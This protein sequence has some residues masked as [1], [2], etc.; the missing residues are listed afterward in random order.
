MKPILNASVMDLFARELDLRA[1]Q[2]LAATTATYTTSSELPPV[3]AAS[4]GLVPAWEAWTKALER[5]D[6][7]RIENRYLRADASY[8]PPATGQAA[9]D[10]FVEAV[11]IHNPSFYTTMTP[12]EVHR[13]AALAAAAALYYAR[14]HAVIEPTVAL[15]TWLAQ[16]DIGKDVPASLFRM[17]MPALFLRFGPE[18]AKAVDPSLWEHTGHAHTTTGVYLFETRVG[19]RR[20]IVFIAVGASPGRPADLP[21]LLQLCLTDES[22]S[23]IE[24]TLNV[25]RIGDIRMGRSVAM[26]QMCAKVLLYLQTPGVIRADELR[27]NETAA[28]LSRVGGK[29]ASKLERRLTSRYNR[30]IVGPSQ[31]IHYGPGE[32]ASHWRR[33]HLRMQAHGPHFSLRKL[34]F[35]APT[36]IRADRLAESVP[37]DH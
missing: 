27:Q 12:G 18:M 16:T 25:A 6:G 32:V 26:V 36:L 22:D 11:R 35:I 1:K 28:C 31:V 37:A 14:P 10:L 34:I 5:L 23:L 7:E 8:G 30:I 3:R 17:P 4:A 24:H 29:K 13:P 15:Q 20:D 19:E 9:T 21:Y 33:G 2:F